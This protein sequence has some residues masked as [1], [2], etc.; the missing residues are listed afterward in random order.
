MKNTWLSKRQLKFFIENKLVS[1]WD[2][3]RFPTVQ[4]IIRRGLCVKAL[5][6]FMLEQGPSQN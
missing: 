6:S 2:D 5:H 4:G 1:G 3:P